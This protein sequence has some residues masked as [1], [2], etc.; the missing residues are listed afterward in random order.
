LVELVQHLR[1]QIHV[2]PLDGMNHLATVGEKAGDVLA[3][4]GQPRNGL[5]ASSPW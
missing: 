5:G 3:L 1:G 2:H 4:V